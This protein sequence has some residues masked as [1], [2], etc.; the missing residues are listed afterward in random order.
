TVHGAHRRS[1]NIDSRGLYVLLRF[2]RRC[3]SLRKIGNFFM[4]LR[5][6]PDVADLSLDKDG[7]IDGFE[8][9]DC[10][11]RLPNVLLEWQ[12]RSVEDNGIKPALGRF[13]SLLQGMRMIC[14]EKNWKIQL[15]PQTTH[16]CGN[17][18][19]SHKLTLA[20]GHT[21]QDRD[22]Q[23]LRGGEHCFQ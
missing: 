14:V 5:T 18:P 8:G 7:R 2:R 6:S 19:D 22:L 16:Q 12:R 9:F 17:L 4:Y 3:Q 10:L 1:Q 11:F 13:Q 20:L 15:L 21:N 23:F